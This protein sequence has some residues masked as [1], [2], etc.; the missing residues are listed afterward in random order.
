MFVA[1]VD[2]F[3]FIV[4]VAF[5]LFF[6]FLQPQ[7]RFCGIG[8]SCYIMRGMHYKD[9]ANGDRRIYIESILCIVYFE[10][11]VEG[12]HTNTHVLYLRMLV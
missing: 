1:V 6:G 5:E 9:L 8:C 3:I 2:I 4:V 10:V 11:C 7:N 12:K